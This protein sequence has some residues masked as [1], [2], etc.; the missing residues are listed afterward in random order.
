MEIKT[1]SEAVVNPV[2][3]KHAPPLGA[4]AVMVGTEG[5][6]LAQCRG[7]GLDENRFQRLFISRLYQSENHR[8]D[9]FAL[10]GP[11]IGAPYAAMLLETLIVWGAS[12]FLF[13]GWCGA[14]SPELKIGDILVPH[15]AT[16]DEGTS[17]HYGAEH[18]SMAYP[19]EPVSQKL[20]GVL[21][22]LGVGFHRGR[23]WS[24]DAIFRETKDKVRHYQS[25]G[26]IA[27]EM[28]LSAL[29]SVAGFRGV[30]I[31]AILVVS[32][33]LSTLQWKPGFKSTEFQ[34]ARA[35]VCEVIAAYVRKHRSGN[36]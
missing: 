26:V 16:I 21:S 35:K 33:E 30:D 18:A 19:S 22:D 27:V 36:H 1:E 8:N 15:S 32:D 14:L 2:K 31:G 7:A 23:V 25:Q 9:S 17:L 12:E 5:D 11:L 20:E 29:C 6:L 10:S 34:Q 24:T 13:Y 28:E 3:R 4:L